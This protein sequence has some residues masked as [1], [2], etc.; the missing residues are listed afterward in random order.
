MKTLSKGDF[1]SYTKQPPP[2]QSTALSAPQWARQAR[3]RPSALA[4]PRSRR[5]HTQPIANAAGTKAAVESGAAEGGGSPPRPARRD[6][7]RTHWAPRAC[8]LARAALR[9]L[10]LIYRASCMVHAVPGYDKLGAR[11]PQAR[12]RRPACRPAPHDVSERSVGGPGAS[13][14]SGMI[15]HTPPPPPPAAATRT[16][17]A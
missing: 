10:A 11:R 3:G 4:A 13:A 16:R 1:P 14:N 17:A 9:M 6:E 12:P 2:P 15:V 5:D 7:G 8:P